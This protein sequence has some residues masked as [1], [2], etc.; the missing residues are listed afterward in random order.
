MFIAQ[1]QIRYVYEEPPN[2]AI[3]LHLNECLYNVPDFVI[4]SVTKYLKNCNLY[5]NK[6]LFDRLR[7]LL[8]EY[9]KTDKDNVYPFVGG[10]GALRSI[11]YTLVNQ[12]NKVL[13][14]DP[15]F[16][17]IKV[18][19][20]ARGLVSVTVNSYEDG[21]WW[22]VDTDVLIEKSRDVN[23]A[24]IVD[25]N[26][27]TGGPVVH[28][29]ED[30]VE[31]LAKNVNGYVVFDEAYH[32]Y[33][34]YTVVP[35]IDRYPNIIVVRSLSKAFCLAGF[36]LGYIVADKNVIERIS[37][38]HTTFDIPTPS[39]VAGISAL[40]NRWYMEKVV[41]SIKEMRNYL[42][43]TFKNLNLKVYRSLTNFLLIRDRR[44]L[45]SILQRHGIYIKKVGEDLYRLTIPPPELCSKI[46]YVIGR[47]L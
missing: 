39:L 45:S 42:Y 3:R 11:F 37:A 47:E 9:T 24:V 29:K 23:L 14:I 33:A 21:D 27:P 31:A 43:E 34:G 12:G 25:P 2:E 7:E 18:Y 28:A 10:D 16:A 46:L 22:R 44:D 8:A 5:P 17:M 26:N 30:V 4:E 19:A 13:Y 32:E 40:E 1:I 38:I 15:T 35:Y 20:E 6:N 41:N 36:R